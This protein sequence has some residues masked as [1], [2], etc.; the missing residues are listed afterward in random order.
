MRVRIDRLGQMEISLCEVAV[1]FAISRQLRDG[2]MTKKIAVSP[3]DWDTLFSQTD[4]A[5][6]R[7]RVSVLENRPLLEIASMGRFIP[8]V[9]DTAL[10][11]GEAEFTFDGGDP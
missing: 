10:T 4:S 2:H 5:P 8:I 3:F 7:Y 9:V 1:R 6:M 11:P